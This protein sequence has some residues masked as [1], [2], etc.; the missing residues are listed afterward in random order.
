MKLARL[1][2]TP[3]ALIDFYQE[4]L[5]ALGAV[6][7]RTWHDRLQLV[8]E[9]PAARLWNP[10]GPLLETEIHFVP[11]EDTAPRQ[12]DKEVFPGCPLTFKLA[13]ELHLHP[14]PLERAVVQPF[15]PPKPPA[16]DVAEK[17]WQAQMPGAS[18]WRLQG[19]PVSDWH[20]SLLV[21]A[22]CEIQAIDQHWT[23]HR[24]AISLPDGRRDESLATRLDFSQLSP[25]SDEVRW[26]PIQL[27]SWHQWLKGAFDQELDVDLQ[28]IR[29]R[30]Q[31]YLRR[32]LERVDSYFEHYESELAERHRRSHA[33]GTRMKAE[34]RLAAAKSEH[35]RRRQDQ[36]RRHEIRVMLHFDALLLVAEPAW[37]A[38]VSFLQKGEG[39]TV[40]ALFVPRSRRW[41]ADGAAF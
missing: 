11:L 19:A 24:V 33:E 16:P 3:S 21:L 31:K 29:A 38:T 28:E 40:S 4:G 2:N 10:E 12:A 23:L 6:C 35:A 15:E 17:L 32:E 20:F 34:E 1:A 22:R 8:A 37:R 39:R 27:D 26:P 9:G 14:L 7:E 36:I 25:A 41:I 30:Q 18:R 13:E 5:E